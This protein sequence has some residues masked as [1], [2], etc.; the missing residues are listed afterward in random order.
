MNNMNKINKIVLKY[1]SINDDKLYIFLKFIDEYYNNFIDKHNNNNEY[2]YYK[3]N[4][5]INKEVDKLDKLEKALNQYNN[6]IKIKS[7]VLE[8]YIFKKN[9]L[10]SIVGYIIKHNN[11]NE[12]LNHNISNLSFLYLAFKYYKYENNI[13]VIKLLLDNGININKLYDDNYTLLMLFCIDNNLNIINLLLDYGADVNIQDKMGN[14]ALMISSNCCDINVIKL[15]ISKGADYNIKNKLGMTVLSAVYYDYYYKQENI[16][17]NKYIDYKEKTT[18]YLNYGLDINNV[19]NNGNTI[20]IKIF[21]NK[22]KYMEIFEWLVNNGADINIQNDLGNSM[23]FLFYNFPTIY[24]TE[25]IKLLINN[26]YNINIKNKNGDTPL[27]YMT[28][29]FYDNNYNK[30]K[31]EIL[32]KSGA[33][34]NI[35]NNNG[36]TALMEYVYLMCMNN[37]YT[38]DMNMIKLF[39]DNGADPN[40]KDFINGNTILS[41][42]FQTQF[43]IKSN[44]E[45]ILYL[46]KISNILLID[47]INL[48]T[49]VPKNLLYKLGIPCINRYKQ[50]IDEGN[51]E[52][53]N[54]LYKFIYI[55][56]F[57]D[58]IVNDL[59][60]N[61][62]INYT[63]KLFNYLIKKGFNISN[64]PNHI[65]GK[66]EI[67]EEECLI[68]NE[69]TMCIKCNYGHYTCNI[70]LKNLNINVTHVK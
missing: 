49:Y 34:I 44:V 38:I 20:L 55:Y 3:L 37:Y 1:I 66:Y 24:F 61:H 14:T 53:K 15:L 67:I 30:N 23:I 56:K 16:Y 6:N 62:Y 36:M 68:C 31:I 59:K 17:Y 39:I 65:I 5:K 26:K 4:K 27:I 8:G 12:L 41:F 13:K 45:I 42:L 69:Y 50:Y 60:D 25:I 21:T 48:F 18:L 33:N 58:T 70:C 2:N 29:N 19:D 10:L 54:I 51:S 28:K 7:W 52:V 43:H 22:Y 63:P 9:I 35:Q 46:I 47:I 32:I 57:N 40:I 64:I 11:S